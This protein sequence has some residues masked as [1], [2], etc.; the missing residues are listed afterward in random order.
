M[1]TPHKHAELIK[2]WAEGAQIEFNAMGHWSSIEKPS[3][4][5][6]FEY[7]IKPAPTPDVVLYARVDLESLQTRAIFTNTGAG[8]S[9]IKMTFDGNTGK[10]AAVSI[11]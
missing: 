3:W 10:L 8:W 7:R 9:N 4:R 11:L 1:E 6:D 2:L 5:D